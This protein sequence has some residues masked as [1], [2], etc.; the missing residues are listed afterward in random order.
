MTAVA[1]RQ[2]Y[3]WWLT[4]HHNRC[5]AEEQKLAPK[6]AQTGANGDIYRK[7]EPL[8]PVRGN[9]LFNGLREVAEKRSEDEN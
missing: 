9:I 6:D 8:S 1:I 3:F 7:E 5:R 2:V 4:L